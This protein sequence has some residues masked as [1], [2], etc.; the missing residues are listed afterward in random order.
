MLAA[1][2]TVV[3]PPAQYLLGRRS[4]RAVVA[5]KYPA[6]PGDWTASSVSARHDEPRLVGHDHKLGA[7]SSG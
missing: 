3:I 2:P 6:E 7:I 1:K 5:G 4:R